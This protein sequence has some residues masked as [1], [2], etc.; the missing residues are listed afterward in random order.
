MRNGFAACQGWA[1]GQTAAD[2]PRKTLTRVDVHS[3]VASCNPQEMNL[4]ATSMLYG[5]GF[6][7]ICF[8]QHS[9]RPTEQ[10][11]LPKLQS[12]RYVC[13]KCWLVETSHWYGRFDIPSRKYEQELPDACGLCSSHTQQ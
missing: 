12:S 3:K 2:S 4:L 10:K 8:V 9:C 1:L 7:L 13:S 5:P 6:S 11:S